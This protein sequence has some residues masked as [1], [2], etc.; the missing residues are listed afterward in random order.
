MQRAAI[1]LDRAWSARLLE[2]PTACGSRQPW[3]AGGDWIDAHD[4][5][6]LCFA[7]LSSLDR[8]SRAA[9]RAVADRNYWLCKRRSR[10]KGRGRECVSAGLAEAGSVL[11]FHH[12]GSRSIPIALCQGLI[13]ETAVMRREC[14]HGGKI[15]WLR[16]SD[17]FVLRFW[18]P[19]GANGSQ[20][21]A[22]PRLRL[23]NHSRDDVFARTTEHSKDIGMRRARVVVEEFD[24]P[25]TLSADFSGR[26]QN[27]LLQQLSPVDRFDC[28][29]E[30]MTAMRIAQSAFAPL[31]FCGKQTLNGTESSEWVGFDCLYSVERQVLS[32]I[33]TCGTGC[34]D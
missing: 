3:L 26:V 14:G 7:S 20:P 16:A 28:A 17:S 6:I 2:F 27:D 34:V 11:Q 4:N 12:N 8:R 21:F 13:F 33:T 29:D 31:L 23:T 10:I 15:G 5:L 19:Q 18:H 24:P 32:P 22:V 25:V 9:S 30:A 1:K